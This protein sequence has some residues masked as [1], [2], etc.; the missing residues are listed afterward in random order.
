M[1]LDVKLQRGATRVTL[2][3]GTELDGTEKTAAKTASVVQ[4]S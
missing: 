3:L 4:G 2:A 1:Q